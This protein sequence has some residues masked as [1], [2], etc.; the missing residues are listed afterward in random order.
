MD[1]KTLGEQFVQRYYS[2][3]ESNRAQCVRN[4]FTEAS[5]YSFEGETLTGMQVTTFPAGFSFLFFFFF[6]DRGENRQP[7]LS[8]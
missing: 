5:T 8:A 6:Q 7:D 1:P 2:E 4:F 3:F